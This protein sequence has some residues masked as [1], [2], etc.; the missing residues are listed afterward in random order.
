MCWGFGSTPT[1]NWKAFPLLAIAWGPLIQ[2]YVYQA[3]EEDNNE[4]FHE[5]GHYIISSYRP[6]S[7]ND[8]ADIFIESMHF[9]E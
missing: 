7:P 3:P 4:F 6:A 5:G 1:N 8:T 2:V 9:I